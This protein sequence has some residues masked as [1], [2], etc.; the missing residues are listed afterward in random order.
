MFDGFPAYTNSSES[1]NNFEF[2]SEPLQLLCLTKSDFNFQKDDIVL[3]SSTL[4]HNAEFKAVSEAAGNT[5]LEAAKQLKTIVLPPPC[6]IRLCEI[7][8]LK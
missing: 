3:S 6:H 8:L 5:D 2:K 7:L 4:Q 1:P